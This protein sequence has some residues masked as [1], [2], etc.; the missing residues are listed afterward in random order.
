MCQVAKRDFGV[1]QIF[2]GRQNKGDEK[3]L[4]NPM[5]YVDPSNDKNQSACLKMYHNQDH[6]GT[7]IRMNF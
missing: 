4:M 1:G 6:K 2:K 7:I 3:E 5:S